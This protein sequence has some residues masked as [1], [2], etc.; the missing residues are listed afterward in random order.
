MGTEKGGKSAKYIL[1]WATK[2]WSKFT[3]ILRGTPQGK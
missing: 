2:L 3:K 1:K